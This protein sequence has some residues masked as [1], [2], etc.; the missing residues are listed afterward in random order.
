MFEKHN[1]GAHQVQCQGGG[2]ATRSPAERL[3]SGSNPDLGFQGGVG[4]NSFLR[5]RSLIFDLSG[6][7][8][9]HCREKI[10]DLRPIT[11]NSGQSGGATPG[12]ISNPEVKPVHVMCGTEIRE[13]SG[14]TSSCYYFLS[15]SVI[16]I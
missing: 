7:P 11:C 9:E 16:R 1:C 15:W 14:T 6:V 5:R 3:H 4:K 13:F 2:A 10:S 8:Q 12:P